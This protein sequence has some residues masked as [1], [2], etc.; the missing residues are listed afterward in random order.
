[1]A[2]SEF[3]QIASFAL[4]TEAGQ[5]KS[6]LE[7]NGIPAFIDGANANTMLSYIGTALGGIKLLVHTTD[8][9]RA[10]EIIGSRIDDSTGACEAWYCGKCQEDV[11]AGFQVCWS[12]G[13]ARADV[14][15]STPMDTNEINTEVELA[16]HLAINAEAESMLQRAWQASIIG[17]LL[18]PIV[19]NLYSMYLLVRASI[20]GA[21]FS[22]TSQKLFYKALVVNLLAGFL[23]SALLR[24]A[25][26]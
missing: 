7:E 22:P 11:D 23:W 19:I 1:M 17:F 8:F 24:V 12:C 16:R 26:W 20:I 10:T 5:F 25:I 2:D 21:E 13:E 18:F 15:Q 3:R 6:I 4:E 14:E 9:E